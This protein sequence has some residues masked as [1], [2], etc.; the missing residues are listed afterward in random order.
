MAGQPL[1]DEQRG[2]RLAATGGSEHR[3]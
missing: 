2:K 3:S 1:G